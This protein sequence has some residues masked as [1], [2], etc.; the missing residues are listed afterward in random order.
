VH[1]EYVRGHCGIEGNEGADALANLGAMEE[2]IEEREWDVLEQS[3]RAGN[4]NKGGEGSGDGNGQ[5]VSA[6]KGSGPAAPSAPASTKGSVATTSA[7]LPV[8]PKNSA[9]AKASAPLATSTDA[10]EIAV[11]LSVTKSS[12]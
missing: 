10:D 9:P 11:G 6:P 3:V 7:V 4:K 2:S 8:P 1:L 5:S 12:F